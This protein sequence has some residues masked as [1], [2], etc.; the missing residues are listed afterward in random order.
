MYNPNDDT[1]QQ[2]HS[3]HSADDSCKSLHTAVQAEP[4]IRCT[5]SSSPRVALLLGT[6]NHFRNPPTS[7]N[8]F[9]AFHAV[10]GTLHSLPS[11]Y[12]PHRYLCAKP[13]SPQRKE[14]PTKKSALICVNR[15]LRSFDQSMTQMVLDGPLW[16]ALFTARTR[17]LGQ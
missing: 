15:C 6:A 7:S 11:I 4:A 17:Y 10:S 12:N 16:P 1:D 9:V 14:Q 3:R 2:H 5:H 13:Q 8:P